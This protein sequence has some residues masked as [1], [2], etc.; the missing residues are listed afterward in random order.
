MHKVQC[1]K[2]KETF[3]LLI[4]DPPPLLPEK[5]N[6]EG[7]RETLILILNYYDIW[8]NLT[9]NACFAHVVNELANFKSIN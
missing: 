3:D 9:K 1:L 7:T 6:L 2:K 5:G 8:S 4:S